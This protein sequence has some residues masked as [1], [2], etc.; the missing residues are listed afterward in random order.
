MLA[1]T[2]HKTRPAGPPN[3]PRNCTTPGLQGRLCI[4]QLG[5]IAV[6]GCSQSAASDLGATDCRDHPQC[7]R[8]LAGDEAR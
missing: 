1:D 7:Y 3:R 6:Q 8:E 2:G 4:L 5:D